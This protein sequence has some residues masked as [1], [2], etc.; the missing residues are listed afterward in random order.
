L[1]HNLIQNKTINCKDLGAYHSG[2]WDKNIHKERDRVTTGD[3]CF[4]HVIG[5]PKK[6]G[7]EIP[8]FDYE[9][10]LYKA[11]L[12][13]SYMN[14]DQKYHSDDLNTDTDTDTRLKLKVHKL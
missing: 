7:K 6:D 12:D 3:C 10:M 8:L 14:S 1:N 13:P 9:K 11:L 4:I 5:L 2:Y